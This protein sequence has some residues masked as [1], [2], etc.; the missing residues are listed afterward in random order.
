MS[1]PHAAEQR[2]QEVSVELGGI[3]IGEPALVIVRPDVSE[4]LSMDNVE[5]P[6]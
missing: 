5:V 1:T 2:Q 3:E 4:Q 6:E